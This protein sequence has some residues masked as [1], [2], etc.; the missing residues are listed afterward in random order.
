MLFVRM[1]LA[2]VSVPPPLKT[3]PPLGTVL[4]DSVQLF[5]V[6]VPK[7]R[8]AAPDFGAERI[9]GAVSGEG[10]VGYR[11]RPFVVDAATTRKAEV[12]RHDAVA[13]RQCAEILYAYKG[14]GDGEPLERR[15]DVRA[16]NLHQPWRQARG[17]RR[18]MRRVGRGRSEPAGV[19]A[20]N[21]FCAG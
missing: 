16:R 12:A 13:H 19:S 21:G 9:A 8:D 14:M 4:P 7:I 11:S 6:I 10:A 3:P 20:R 15:R 18:S 17:A 2:T 1:L 5:T